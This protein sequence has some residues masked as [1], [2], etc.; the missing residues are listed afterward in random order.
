MPKTIVF[1]DL[2]FEECLSL[3]AFRVRLFEEGEHVGT[4]ILTRRTANIGIQKAIDA[5][6]KQDE[7]PANIVAFKRGGHADTA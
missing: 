6:A 1:D 2:D 3:N 5:L 7:R 4:L